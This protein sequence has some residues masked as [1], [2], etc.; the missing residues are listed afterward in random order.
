MS[1]GGSQVQARLDPVAQVNNIIEGLS[2]SISQLCFPA[3]WPHFE[4]GPLCTV[5]RMA[6]RATVLHSI[7]LANAEKV[8][9]LLRCTNL[10]HILIPERVADGQINEGF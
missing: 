4:V 1:R 5:T 3:Y 2:P 8:Q 10:S 6:P 9:R 7:S